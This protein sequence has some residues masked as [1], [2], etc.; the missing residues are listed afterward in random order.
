MQYK[1]LLL[2]SFVKKSQ[3]DIFLSDLSE[4]H[5]VKPDK[6]FVFE[7]NEDTYLLTYKLKVDLGVRFDIKR[8]L[9]KTIQIHK[10]RLTFFTINALNKLIERDCGLFEGNIN[11]IEHQIDWELYQNKL[12]L[13]KNNRLEVSDIKRVFLSNS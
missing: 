1:I 10:K 2:A 8:E 5:N 12:V 11:H 3:L 6:V 7:L 4:K 13:L 9:P